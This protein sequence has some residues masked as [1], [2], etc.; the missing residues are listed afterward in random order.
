M[1]SSEADGPTDYAT[2]INLEI[3]AQLL[4]IR[5]HVLVLATILA[6]TAILGLILFF[7]LLG[8]LPDSVPSRGY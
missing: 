2:R 1:E 6:T 4:A 3:L 5:R 7:V 8:N